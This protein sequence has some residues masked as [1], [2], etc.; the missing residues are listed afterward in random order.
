MKNLILTSAIVCVS[1][2]IG[3]QQDA[4]YTHYA[5]NTLAVNPAYA[6]SREALTMTVLHR[7]QWVGIEGAPTTQTLTMHTPLREDMGVG[8]SLMNDRIG[9][10]NNTSLYV[11]YAYKIPVL[12]G[13]LSMA[14][15]G[16]LDIMQANLS[17]LSPS[18]A[19]DNSINNNGRNGIMPN[20]GLGTYYSTDRFYVGISSP[21]LIH[22]KTNIQNTDINGASQK[23]SFY[24]IGGTM[25][26]INENLS[27]KPMS[28]IKM[29]GGAPIQADITGMVVIDSKFELGAM[30]RTRDAAGILCG[31][32]FES[33]LRVGYSFDWSFGVNSSSHELVLRYD[34]I[35]N[36]RKKIVSPRYF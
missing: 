26:K 7:S 4:M 28:L 3:A 19:G 36:V 30:Y 1:F 25:L 34:F 31:I 16:G 9:P 23:R 24:I 17:S 33:H 22:N 14:L 12:N 10:T 27:F 18:D 15:K 11:D 2:F 6:G 29:T 8:F 32:N 21:R 35:Q 13:K 5:F 20:F